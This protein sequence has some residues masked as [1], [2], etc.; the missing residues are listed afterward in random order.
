VLC[1]AEAGLVAVGNRRR[2]MLLYAI[3]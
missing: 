1:I 2:L 3:G